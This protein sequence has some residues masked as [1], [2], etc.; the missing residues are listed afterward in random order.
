[1]GG[2]SEILKDSSVRDKE[3]CSVV[4]GIATRGAH[5]DRHKLRACDGLLMGSIVHKN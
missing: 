1:M 4:S 5:A 3:E 2:K